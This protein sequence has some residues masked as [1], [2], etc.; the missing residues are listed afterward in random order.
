ML[1]FSPRRVYP[2]HQPRLLH[3]KFRVQLQWLKVHRPWLLLPPQVLLRQA[4]RANPVRSRSTWKS[5]TGPNLNPL[6]YNGY[7]APDT[8]MYTVYQS[9][10]TVNGS[11]LY[12]SG[13][14]QVLPMLAA[15]WTAN[16]NDTT[17][18]FNLRQGINFSNG[19]SFNSYQVWAQMYATYF[20]AA[21]SS[22]SLTCTTYSTSPESTSDPR[23][24]P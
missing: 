22:T 7:V 20:L 15:N 5:G 8:M 9:L 4:I 13:N 17:Y 10:T 3:R 11:M 6:A 14:V 21:N 12:D 16:P 2:H 1:P 24:S 19:D 18:T 23:R